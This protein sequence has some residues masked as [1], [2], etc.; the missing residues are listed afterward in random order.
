MVKKK[1][2]SHLKDNFINNGYDKMEYMILQMFSSIPINDDILKNELNILNENDRN[3]I[4]F[5]LN[6]DIKRVLKKINRK[7]NV[8]K[9][10]IHKSEESCFVF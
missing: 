3:I 7:E 5:Q 2:L 1:N 8:K 4:L 9:N 10:I 6:K